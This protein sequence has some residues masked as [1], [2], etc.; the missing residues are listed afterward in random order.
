MLRDARAVLRQSSETATNAST[1]TGTFS[2]EGPL[3]RRGARMPAHVA[4]ELDDEIAEAVEH[5]RVLLEPRCGLDVTDDLEPLRD[6]IQVAES[7]LKGRE[8]RQGREGGGTIP[9]RRA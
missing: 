3:T 4:P 9:P 5:C 6:A 7:S 2:G 1:M 8:N